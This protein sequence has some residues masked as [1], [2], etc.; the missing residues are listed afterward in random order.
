MSQE[1]GQVVTREALPQLRHGAAAVVLVLDVEARTVVHATTGALDLGGDVDGPAVAVER[2]VQ[3]AQLARPD[4][5]PFGPGEDPVSRAARG[6]TVLGEAVRVPGVVVD[7]PMWATGFPLPPR[8]GEAHALLVLV[9]LED[10]TGAAEAAVRDRAVIAAGLSFTISDATQP[11]NPLVFINPAFERATGYSWEEVRGRNCRFL[12]GPDTDPSAVQEIR[13]AIERQEHAV[14]TLLN[15]RKD[16]S[17]FWNE[18]SLSPVYDGTGALTHYVGIQADVTARVVAEQERA[19][20]LE[21]E[22]RARAESER[23]QARLALLAEA[24]TMLAATLDVD[25]ALRRL[26]ALVVPVMADWCMVELG[27]D[28]PEERRAVFSHVD[29]GKEP[30]LERI[31]E[32]QPLQ[33]TSDSPVRKV[34]DSGQPMLVHEITDELLERLGGGDELS[35]TYAELG[36]RSGLVVPLR[37]RRQVLG[38]LSLIS[39][40]SGR[41]YDEADLSMAADL[42]RRAALA[43]DNAR[44]YSREH[45]VAE[46]LQRS[47]LPQLPDVTGLDRAARYLPGSTAAQVGGDWYDLFVLPDGV[48]GV[49]IGDVMGH[50]LQAAASMGQL[51]SV[52][53]SYAWQGSG[54]ALVLDHLDQLV[55]GLEMAQLATAAYGRLSLPTADGPGRLRLANAG[56]LPPVL[57]RPDGSTVLLDGVASLLVGATLGVERQELE[58]EVPSGSV[59]VLCTDGLVERRGLDPDEGL[60]R[61]RAVVE[62]ATATTAQELC[63]AVLQELAAGDLDDDVALLVVRVL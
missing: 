49:A 22:R 19:R 50:D 59:L 20:H 58:V 45:A 35:R 60:E 51:R 10:V 56:H 57:R 21:A 37:A 30:L 1:E 3:G 33:R 14:V 47:L 29:P 62:Q 38:V 52:L 12:Q 24:T 6:Q 5:T 53:R 9:E 17:P 26:A 54:P 61:L 42:A 32:L 40:E 7:R 13:D 23:A 41:V 27:I 63:D 25:E 46:Q 55:Q 39:S 44:L 43:V 48:V 11:D 8:H 28:D 2:W 4:G 15:R 34:L 16:G 31:G 18:L 36:G